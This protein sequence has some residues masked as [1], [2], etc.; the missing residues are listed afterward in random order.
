MGAYE[1][2]AGV[3]SSSPEGVDLLHRHGIIKALYGVSG[4][5]ARDDLNRL[6]I[7]TLDY[8]LYGAAACGHSSAD[9][10]RCS[11]GHSQILLGKLITAGSKARG[12]EP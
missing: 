5:P 9:L 7:S 6:L 2:G 8:N 10:T 11:N 3:L 1:S 12:R 4:L